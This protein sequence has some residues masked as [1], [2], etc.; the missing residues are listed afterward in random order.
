MSRTLLRGAQVISMA[1][2][3]P[4]VERVDILVDDDRIAAVGD[5]LDR[6]DDDT[7]DF[8]GRIVMP[9]LINAHLHTWQSGLRCV[10]ADWT[11]LQYLTHL[12]GGVARHYSP[13]D[14]FIGA[15]A[16]ALNQIN[17]GTT[18]IGDWCR[19]GRLGASA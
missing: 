11:L 1:P 7:I 9:G 18:T 19:R 2:G 6:S 4:D 16:G 14:M 12:H 3:R 5:H 13:D 17:C 8:S 10:G 15:L